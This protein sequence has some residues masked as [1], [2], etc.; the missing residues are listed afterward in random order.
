MAGNRLL[1]MFMSFIVSYRLLF[2]ELSSIFFSSMDKPLYII[3]ID[4]G[5]TKTTSVLCALDGVI[6]AEAQGAPSNFQI[7]GIE[8]TSH[9]I[10]D[11][12]ETCCH[13]AGCS[14]S[15]I[16]AV[17]AGLAGAGRSNDQ[18]SMRD[19]IMDAAHT[20]NLTIN[21]LVVESDAR[22][23]LE[24]AFGGKPGMIVIAGT[25]SIVFGKDERGKIYRAGGWGRLIGDEGSGYAIGQQA[26]RAV[27]R[28]LDD[29]S[30]KTKLTKLFEKKFGLNTQEAIIQSLYK[31]N[32]DIASVMPTV[33][34]A[35]SKGDKAAKRI[36]D[37]AALEL[38]EIIDIALKKMNT[39]IK[40]PSK[41]PLALIGGL[42]ANE[43]YYSRKVISV[44]RKNLLPVT[45]R[46]AESSPVVGAAVMAI[47][48]LKS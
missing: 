24:G 43:H 7:I 45:V 17:V 23:A 31:E 39:N 32:F 2:I 19:G 21:N 42:L 5:G 34:D 20:R 18:Q 33:I 30:T 3:G 38:V 40:N 13:S 41:R 36:L 29:K 47:D 25:G 27:A 22:I 12:V 11:L 9:T 4:G 6:L 46:Q 10:L 44:I 35:A 15:Q 26:F 1:L 8:R 14:I 16:G 48:L 37:N 28:S